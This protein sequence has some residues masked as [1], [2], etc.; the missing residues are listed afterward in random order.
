M[1]HATPPSRQTIDQYNTYTVEGRK[2]FL[3]DVVSNNGFQNLDA[4]LKISIDVPTSE[5][6][7]DMTATMQQKKIPFAFISNCPLKR[8]TGPL[9]RTIR[10]FV[11]D[12]FHFD[13]V[14]GDLSK[15]KQRHTSKLQQLEN[16]PEG[17][18]D[19]VL[20]KDTKKLLSDASDQYAYYAKLNSLPIVPAG[21]G[22]FA[23]DVEN[24]RNFLI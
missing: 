20:I 18:R 14:L 5:V 2:N 11:Y 22:F 23:I 1:A 9:Q 12:R 13:R 4:I 8:A 19:L 15:E 16:K 17:E 7:Q 3:T 21:P 10:L 24:L 6:I